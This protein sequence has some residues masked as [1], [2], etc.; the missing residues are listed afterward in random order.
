MSTRPRKLTA[1]SLENAAL[2]YLERFG[3]SA[4]NL[5][6]VLLRRVERSARIHDTDRQA[7]AALVDE[8]IARYR[9]SGLLD[10]RTYAE[11][12][13][14]SLHRRG[15][16][17]HGIRQRLRAKGVGDDDI[18]AALQALADGT[19][20]AAA[21]NLARRRRLGPFRDP[22][23]R[24]GLRDKD[25]AAMARAGFDLD[26]ARRVIDAEDLAALHIPPFEPDGDD[27]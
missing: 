4:D 9:A 11:G 19:A 26:T 2:Y 10:D 5:R 6:R 18:T 22:A 3:T 17:A 16:P 7:G 14:A 21:V 1:A 13:A 27:R 20:E 24:A 12:R 8:L 23:R 25:L 15:V